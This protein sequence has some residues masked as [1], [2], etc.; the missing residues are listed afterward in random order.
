MDRIP[1]NSSDI[2][3][4]GYDLDTCVLEVAFLKGGIYQYDGVPIYVYEE[5]MSAV[6]HGRYFAAHIKNVYPTRRIG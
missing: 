5:L 1:V 6:S 4:I 2:Q 3:S